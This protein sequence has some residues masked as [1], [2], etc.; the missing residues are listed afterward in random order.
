[1]ENTKNHGSQSHTKD[2][3]DSVNKDKKTEG[4][5][6]KTGAQN[7]GSNS[8]SRMSDSDD[9]DNDSNNNMGNKPGSKSGSR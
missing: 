5:K 9:E 8:G 3:G 7:S 1:M 2:S 4:Q 6:G